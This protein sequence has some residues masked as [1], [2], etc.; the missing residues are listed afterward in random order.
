[1]RKSAMT[2]SAG[3]VVLGPMLAWGSPPDDA[4]RPLDA[5]IA[6]A[7]AHAHPLVTVE[8]DAPFDDLAPLAAMIGDARLVGLGE[9]THGTR[10]IFRMKHRL[11]AYLVETMG[12][13]TFGIEASFP[14]CVAINRYVEFGEGDPAAALHGQQFWT[15]DTEEVLDLIEWMRA[16]NA[17][18]ERD[19]TL[20]FYGFDM[21][22]GAS[23]ATAALDWLGRVDADL[24]GLAE[25]ET[26]LKD[27]CD[28]MFQQRYAALDADA[29]TALTAS[30]E[31]LVELFERHRARLT[32]ATSAR[33]FDLA[34]RHAVVARQNEELVRLM[35]G[36]SSTLGPEETMRIG[37]N[38]QATVQ[39]LISFFDQFDSTWLEGEGRSILEPLDRNP[40][41]L[42]QR[43]QASEPEEQAAWKADAARI[44]A[45]LD[46]M[47]AAYEARGGGA[48][49]AT[50]A[51]RA[52]DLQ[53]FFV[54]CEDVAKR[55]NQGA[56]PNV[57]DRCMA[58][59]AAWILEREGPDAKAALWA[60][61]GHLLHDQAAPG[62][63]PMGTNLRAQFGDD[64]VVIGFA[65]NEGAFQAIWRPEPGQAWDGD[66]ALREHVVS[67]ALEDSIDGVLTATDL[68]MLMIDVRTAPRGGPAGEWWRSARRHRMIGAVFNAA[69]AFN[70]VRPTIAPEEYDVLVFFAR[71]TA[72]RPNP[73]T[74]EKFGME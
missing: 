45:R 27:F 62:F 73:L 15:W 22:N 21:Q 32:E 42:L 11:F 64:Y 67:S 59:N 17:D 18:P 6:W 31:A 24:P 60:H 30:V 53:L 56:Q 29:R 28:P 70:Y 26:G 4:V 10:E 57:R 66:P 72:A 12:F 51:R 2:W 69:Q 35:H 1:M 7:K 38:H 33:D 44:G 55:M 71:T 63:G 41:L 61:N 74:R 58:E 20:R 65:F 19:R 37:R 68:P 23:A 40:E 50:A 9:S 43:Y 36:F 25:V 5:A 16:Y 52:T 54:V 39:G 48:A 47:R 49:L 8:A 14:E 3:L 46:A 13:T 34:H